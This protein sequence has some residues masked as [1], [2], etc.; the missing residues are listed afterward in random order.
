MVGFGYHHITLDGNTVMRD[1]YAVKI[2]GNRET[3]D[4]R[5]GCTLVSLAALRRLLELSE[6]VVTNNPSVFLQSG[7]D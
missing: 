7:R 2:T 4:I 5:V 1:G 3:G 6:S